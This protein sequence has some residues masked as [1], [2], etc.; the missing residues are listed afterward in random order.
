M[1]SI[2]IKCIFALCLIHKDNKN[3]DNTR[4]ETKLREDDRIISIN[5]KG[6]KIMSI[7]TLIACAVVAIAAIACNVSFFSG[8]MK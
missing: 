5:L 6:K 4:V 1:R 7:F 3:K 2:K 8:N